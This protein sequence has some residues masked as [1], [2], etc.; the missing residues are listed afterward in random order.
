LPH[1]K[2]LQSELRHFEYE[3]SASGNVRYGAAGASDS[4]SWRERP[5]DDLTLA[6]AIAARHQ[7]RRDAWRGHARS[8]H[9]ETLCVERE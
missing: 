8:R 3:I 1:A 2:I 7:A 5:H 6:L 9:A 4:L